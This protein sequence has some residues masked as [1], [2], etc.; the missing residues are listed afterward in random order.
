MSVE[1][2]YKINIYTL[3]AKEEERD[4]KDRIRELVSKLDK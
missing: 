2:K 1:S 4:S 3:S